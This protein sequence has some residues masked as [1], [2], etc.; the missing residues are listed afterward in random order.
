M[1]GPEVASDVPTE[2]LRTTDGRLWFM[3]GDHAILTFVRESGEV[4]EIHAMWIGPR[5]PGAGWVCTD[6]TRLPPRPRPVVKI[7]I[8]WPEEH[9]AIEYINH[10]EHTTPEDSTHD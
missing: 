4:D 8:V 10:T 9:H 2:P 5:G 6:G 7:V 3:P 1:S